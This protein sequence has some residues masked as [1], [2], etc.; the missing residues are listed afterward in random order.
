MRKLCTLVLLVALACAGALDP[1]L[2][3]ADHGDKERLESLLDGGA[4]PNALSG[5]FKGTALHSAAYYGYVQLAKLLLDHGTK[6]DIVNINGATP[7]HNA[8]LNGKIRAAKFLLDKGADVHLRDN[9]GQTP[10][11]YTAMNGGHPRVAKL[12]LDKGAEVNAQDSSGR[13]PLH[14]SAGSGNLQVAKLLLARGANKARR[15]LLV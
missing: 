3:A 12:L 6:L 10:L 11:H 14:H 15:E 1:L 2:A 8:A 4:E 13:A 7:L 5:P 9:A